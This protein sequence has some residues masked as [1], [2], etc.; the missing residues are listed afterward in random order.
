M[1][2]ID[3]FFD[4][5]KCGEHALVNLNPHFALVPKYTG[6]VSLFVHTVDRGDDFYTHTLL[7]DRRIP[8]SADL[9]RKNI[10]CNLRERFR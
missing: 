7:Q 2:S 8:P 4:F 9:Q 1:D 5:L 6:R 3:Q 10:L